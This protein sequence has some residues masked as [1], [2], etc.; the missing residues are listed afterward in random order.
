MKHCR[1][2]GIALDIDGVLLRGSKIIPRARD[3]MKLIH[4]HEIPHVFMT[5]G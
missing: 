1:G 4:D 3:A 5:N 2:L